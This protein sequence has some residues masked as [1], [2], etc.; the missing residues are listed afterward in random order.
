VS[1]GVIRGRIEV[2]LDERTDGVIQEVTPEPPGVSKR[3]SPKRGWRAETSQDCELRTGM[4]QKID[5]YA[6][7][8]SSVKYIT[9][10]PKSGARVRIYF[11]LF[12]YMMKEKIHGTENFFGVPPMRLGIGV[13]PPEYP[14]GIHAG[15]LSE[16]LI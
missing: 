4:W 5:F 7:T 8:C 13:R 11:M 12:K 15:F 2:G 1:G 10:S 6:H 9:S 3:G 14:V 16:T